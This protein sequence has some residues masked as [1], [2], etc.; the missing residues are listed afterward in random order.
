MQSILDS[1]KSIIMTVDHGITR[2]TRDGF[3]RSLEIVM[4]ALLPKPFFILV[5]GDEMNRVIL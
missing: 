3:V 2:I 4:S 1:N 5:V